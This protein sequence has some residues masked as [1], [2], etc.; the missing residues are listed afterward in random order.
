MIGPNFANFEERYE[1]LKKEYVY[2]EWRKRLTIHIIGGDCCDAEEV[3]KELT[4]EQIRAVFNIGYK[5][6]MSQ[7]LE[8]I[9]KKERSTEPTDKALLEVLQELSTQIMDRL[10]TQKCF[11]MYEKSSRL[12]MAIHRERHHTN[13]PERQVSEWGEHSM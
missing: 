12:S 11:A 2:N 8:S 9:N 3:F 7:T 5:F 13:L 1:R 10:E 4:S 6:A